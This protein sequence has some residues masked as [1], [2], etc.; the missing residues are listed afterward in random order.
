MRPSSPFRGERGE[1]LQARQMDLVLDRAVFEATRCACCSKATPPRRSAPPASRNRHACRRRSPLRAR[2]RAAGSRRHRRRSRR[3]GRRARRRDRWSSPRPV[4]A[5]DRG[6]ALGI[7]AD[8]QQARNQPIVGERQTA[9]LDDRQRQ[10]IGQMLRRQPMRPVAPL[11]MIPIVWVAIVGPAG[12]RKVRGDRGK[13]WEQALGKVRG[14]PRLRYAGRAPV[15]VP[16]EQGAPPHR[17]PDLRLRHAIRVHRPRHDDADAALARGIRP[18]RRAAHSRLAQV[19]RPARDLVRPW[20]H[21]RESQSARLRGRG[22]GRPR[23]GTPQLGA[24]TACA[25]DPAGRGG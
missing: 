24:H 17:L 13:P 14:A 25:A 22:P 9:F 10:G 23:G 2:R 19:L 1:L 6:K 3:R 21:H 5:R 20:L 8:Q 18:R 15:D 12:L 4:G 7:A 16:R 11:T